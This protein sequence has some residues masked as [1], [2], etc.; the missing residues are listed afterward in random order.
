MSVSIE[1]NLAGE[2]GSLV[3]DEHRVY[4]NREFIT[5]SSSVDMEQSAGIYLAVIVATAAAAAWRHII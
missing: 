2:T 4:R 5:S 1:Y 3:V